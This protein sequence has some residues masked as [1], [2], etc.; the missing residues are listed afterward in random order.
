MGH[1]RDWCR[2]TRWARRIRSNWWRRNGTRFHST[3]TCRPFLRLKQS[4]NDGI[5][6][7]RIDNV[8][9]DRLRFE[10]SAGS[11]QEVEDGF[12]N[13]KPSRRYG[14]QQRKTSARD[15]ERRDVLVGKST[16]R[17][18]PKDARKRVA[19]PSSRHVGDTSQQRTITSSRP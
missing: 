5:R 13:G 11:S 4:T 3:F 17:P 18:I 15:E 6:R 9:F 19:P 16:R 12:R 8:R 10:R 7:S 1:T 2:N 14:K